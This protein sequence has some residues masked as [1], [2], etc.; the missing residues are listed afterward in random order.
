MSLGEQIK[1]YCD[2][3]LMPITEKD[4]IEYIHF[5]IHN[6]YYKLVKTHSMFLPLYI[7]NSEK[8]IGFHEEEI[9]PFPVGMKMISKNT[10]KNVEIERIEGGDFDIHRFVYGVCGYNFLRYSHRELVPNLNKQ[11]TLVDV[12][13]D[14]SDEDKKIIEKHIK[15]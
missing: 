10:N 11:R 15:K 1:E 9:K 14:L 8:I 6:E 3:G 12:F 5:K 13:A 7:T 4:E 2:Y